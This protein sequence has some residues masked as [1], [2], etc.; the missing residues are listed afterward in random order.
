M[1]VKMQHAFPQPTPSSFPEALLPTC[2]DHV[3][4]MHM[5][6]GGRDLTVSFKQRRSGGPG[7]GDFLPAWC[8]HARWVEKKAA[9]CVL[10][11]G[12]DLRLLEGSEQGFPLF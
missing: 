5:R 12:S 2:R 6:G 4:E 8:E 11:T 3:G 7:C 10:V 9:G 1:H